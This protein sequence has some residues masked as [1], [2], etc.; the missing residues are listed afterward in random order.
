MSK[1]E[2]ITVTIK[3]NIGKS[4]EEKN[5]TQDLY[6]KM[7]CLLNQV[8]INQSSSSSIDLNSL[9]EKEINKSVTATKEVT[10]PETKKKVTEPVPEI[11]EKVTETV[12]ALKEKVTEPVTATNE[13][14]TEP[15]TA[16]K[17]KVTEPETAPI[18]E[19]KKPETA[20]IEVKKSETER[21]DELTAEIATMKKS[22]V[23][24]N[25]LLPLFQQAL[26]K[27][28]ETK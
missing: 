13:K 25:N 3:V 17:E 2:N 21:I 9:R 7:F 23:N 20:P 14:V 19:V 16:L 5:N 12:T 11:K 4:E 1:P 22:L 24:L 8:L 6:N 15:V 18:E 26:E 27:L 28:T 10:T